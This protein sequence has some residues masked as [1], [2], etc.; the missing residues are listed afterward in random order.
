MIFTIDIQTTS[1]YESVNATFKNLLQNSNN[2]LVDIFFTIEERLEEEQDNT[3]YLNW[4]NSLTTIQ[5]STIASNAFTDVINELKDFTT[6]SI[7]KIHNNEME[8]AFSYDA[9]PLDQSYINNE[10]SHV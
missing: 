5:S 3:D 4:Q 6:P 7:Q 10:D 1:R 8:L 2:T 9:R